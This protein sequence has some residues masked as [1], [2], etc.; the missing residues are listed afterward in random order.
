M[1]IY[2]SVVVSFVNLTQCTITWKRRLNELSRLG[3]PVAV[4]VKDF[5]NGL[6]EVGIPTLN[7]GSPT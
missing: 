1:C 2:M 6:T 7:M 4:P 3:R 5:L